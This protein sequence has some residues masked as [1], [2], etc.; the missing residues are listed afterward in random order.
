MSALANYADGNRFYHNFKHIGLMID[1]LERHYFLS[2]ESYTYMTLK[3]AILYHDVIYNANY[4]DNE[5]LSAKA[6]LD[7]L[8]D[9]YNLEFIQEVQRLIMITKH[10]QPEADD[11]AGCIITDLDLAGLAS[12]NYIRHSQQIRKEYAFATDVQW[13]YGRKSFLDNFLARPTIYHTEVGFLRWE[14]DARRNMQLEL[15][16][17]E[18]KIAALKGF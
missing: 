12:H 2:K 15:N 5:F 6:A 10:H 8:C 4:N 14:A 18:A 1:G 11:D 16:Y 3:Y 17:I 7:D 13:Y 9:E